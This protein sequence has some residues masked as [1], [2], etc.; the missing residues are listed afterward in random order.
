MINLI[1]IIFL[2]S[3][4]SLIPL[5]PFH[6]LFIKEKNNFE[7]Y[8]IGIFNL[9]FF[10]NLILILTFFS[11]NLTQLFFFVISFSI[12][13]FI[14]KYKYIEFKKNILSNMLIFFLTLVFSVDLLFNLE[15]YWDAQK[16]WLNKS[17]IFFNSGT[18][19]D[20][21][22]S[23]KPNYPFFGS[24]IWSFFWKISFSDYEIFG[25][26]I[27]I[28]IFLHCLYFISS[29]AKLN[30][31][32][33]IFLFFLLVFLIYDYWHFRGTQEILVFSSLLI[34]SCA[35]YLIKNKKQ[36]FENYIIFFLSL[37]LLI[38]TKNEG[39]VLSLFLLISII[40]DQKFSYNKIF[41]ISLIFA[42]L[43]CLRYLIYKYYNLELNLSRDFDYKFLHKNFLGNLNLFN[44]TLILKHLIISI[45]KFPYILISLIFFGYTIK[46]IE[47][48]TYVNFV[49]LFFL[50]IFFIFFIYLSTSKDILLMVPTGLNRIAFESFA[51]MLIFILIYIDKNY[52]NFRFFKKK[53]NFFNR[54]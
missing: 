21:S 31:K 42:F 48:K 23:V 50:T 53:M 2:I 13:I 8:N 20:L 24:L 9:F 22:L 4:I 26:I 1:Q 52:K 41:K 47:L 35:I 37:N 28:F 54:K 33:R 36:I 32:G 25:R 40:L 18:I 38:W 43:L 51:F 11:L 44:V 3:F 19:E 30:F 16:V 46:H 10:L 27:F 39:I 12:L 6:S 5:I 14:F 17:I 49:F 45:F 7:N 15:L 34:C 29:L